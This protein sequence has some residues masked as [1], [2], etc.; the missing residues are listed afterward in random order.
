[1]TAT[2]STEGSVIEQRASWARILAP[3][4]GTAE[5]D[6]VLSAAAGLAG[7]FG[8]EVRAAYTPTDPAQF[9][10]LMGEG[11][12]GGVQLAAMDTLRA[13]SDEGEGRARAA[14][15]SAG[16]FVSLTS[17]VWAALGMEARLADVVVFSREA[18]RGRPPMADFFRQILSEERRPVLVA[19]SDLAAGGLAAVAWDGG[20]EATRAARSALPWL[21]RADRVVILTA[22]AGARRSVE[23]ERLQEHF[24]VRGVSAEVEVLS[25]SGEPAPYLLDR[26]RSLSAN[27][28]VAGAFGHPRLQEFIFGGTTR[29]LLS[30]DGPALFLSH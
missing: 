14:A 10:P 28:L 23:P 7:P 12:M 15:A 5:D 17:P 30:A 3:L 9:M 4:S 16:S 19:S 26:A 13:A 20:K 6:I 29:A 2:E 1:M 24:A 27:L 8:A 25:Q 18:A 22:P 11:F 21:Q